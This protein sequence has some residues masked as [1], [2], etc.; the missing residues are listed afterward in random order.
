MVFA[1]GWRSLRWRSSLRLT[2]GAAL[3]IPLG[4]LVLTQAPANVVQRGL[5]VSLIVIGLYSLVAPRLVELHHPWWAYASGFASGLLGGAYNTNAPPVVLYGA[6]RRWPPPVFRATLQAYFVPTAALIW[7][8]HG[9]TGLWSR[10]IF[11]WYVLYL[12]FGVA[13]LW[14]GQRLSG[15]LPERSFD[16]LLYAVII[17]LGVTLLI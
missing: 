1:Q 12:P 3:G 9:L 13:V 7:A 16:R 11:G 2:V 10:E 8:G 15:L 6:L 17:V 5:G 4:I 14:V